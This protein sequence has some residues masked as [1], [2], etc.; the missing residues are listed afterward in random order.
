MHP[1]RWKV[2]RSENLKNRQWNQIPN[3]LESK[4]KNRT[5]CG[6][7]FCPPVAGGYQTCW[8]EGAFVY[9]EDGGGGSGG[10]GGGG[11]SGG[12]RSEVTVN[13][14]IIESKNMHKSLG[15]GVRVPRIQL[16]DNLVQIQAMRLA[17]VQ[18]FGLNVWWPNRVLSVPQIDVFACAD[19]K[20]VNLYVYLRNFTKKSWFYRTD[21]QIAK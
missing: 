4:R 3:C 16:G 14:L 2:H 19:I 21:T 17:N 12:S 11:G 18:T 8:F 7:N 15:V 5:S 13:S 10:G 9:L 6:W 20:M 1:H